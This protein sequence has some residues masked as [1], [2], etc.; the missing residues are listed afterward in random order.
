MNNTD[1]MTTKP[2]RDGMR[3]CDELMLINKPEKQND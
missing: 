2:M 1:K 3:E